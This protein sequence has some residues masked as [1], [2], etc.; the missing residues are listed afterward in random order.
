MPQLD[1]TMQGHEGLFREGVQSVNC[2]IGT[3]P[4]QGYHREHHSSAPAAPADFAVPSSPV[5]GTT[6]PPRVF[7]EATTVARAQDGDTDAFEQLVRSYEA[8]LFRLGFRMLA[9]RGEAQDAVQDTFV[10]AWRRL[11]SVLDPEAFRAW[12]YQLMTRRCLN[13]LR[14]R[15]RRH[16]GVTNGPDFELEARAGRPLPAD[17]TTDPETAA[18]TN[19]MQDCLTAVLATL[20]PDQR[21]CWVLHEMHALTYPAIAYAIGVPVSTVRGR[22]ARARLQLAKGMTAWR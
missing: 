19:A 6:S 21:A 11:P 13:I 14:V 5:A 15:V 16:T 20:P 2:A 9:D 7:S 12:I 3:G 18:Q 17:S 10:L 1:A 4:D 22:I 8:D